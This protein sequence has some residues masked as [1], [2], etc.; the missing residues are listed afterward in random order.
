[1]MDDSNGLQHISLFTTPFSTPPPPGQD[2]SQPEHDELVS[3]ASVL[4][5]PCVSPSLVSLE[6]LES[7]LNDGIDTLDD[8]DIDD[9]IRRDISST[10]PS[11]PL[12]PHCSLSPVTPHHSLSSESDHQLSPSLPQNNSP[13]SHPCL[14]FRLPLKWSTESGTT[15]SDSS[16]HSLKCIKLSDGQNSMNSTMEE[17]DR[18]NEHPDAD[19]AD[20][21]MG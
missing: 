5:S 7:E 13:E 16:V 11:S 6:D 8:K 12:T 4:F 14:V 18:V 19:M 21:N 17:A 1:M 15:T 2:I 20:E 10:A 3:A 9:D